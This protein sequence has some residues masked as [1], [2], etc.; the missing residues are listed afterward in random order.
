MVLLGQLGTQL[1]ARVGICIQRTYLFNVGFGSSVDKILFTAHRICIVCL[2][3][4]HSSP[5][6]LCLVRRVAR[7]AFAEIAGLDFS[8]VGIVSQ[9]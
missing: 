9:R 3:G 1:L 6:A 7:W 4:F 2:Y 8:A 5:G